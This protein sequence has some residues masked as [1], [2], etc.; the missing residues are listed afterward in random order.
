ML[1]FI[2]DVLCYPTHPW[3]PR[4]TRSREAA[5]N[6]ASGT[7]PGLQQSISRFNLFMPAAITTLSTGFFSFSVAMSRESD[8]IS[9]SSSIDLGVSQSEG[10]QRENKKSG[11]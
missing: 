7:V 5:R 8:A 3:I 11:V 4:L 9:S 2:T 1:L 10:E 6:S